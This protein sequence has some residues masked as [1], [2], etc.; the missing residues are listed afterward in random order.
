MP[1]GDEPHPTK[2]ID[3]TMLVLHSG[4]ERTEDA[5]RELLDSAGFTLD[6]IV[7]NSSPYCVIEATL[8]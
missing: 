2:V 3:I 6:R 4:R 1:A 7:R 8:R 5:Y